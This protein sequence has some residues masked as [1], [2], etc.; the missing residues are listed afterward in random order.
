MGDR[1]GP[2][3]TWETGHVT[4]ASGLASRCQVNWS[5]SMDRQEAL[6]SLC[7]FCCS[8]NC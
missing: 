5:M 2:V 4:G 6:V 3:G 7:V 8:K 1:V